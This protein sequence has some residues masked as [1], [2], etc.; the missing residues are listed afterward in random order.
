M[1]TSLGGNAPESPPQFQAGRCRLRHSLGT[2]GGPIQ[3]RAGAHLNSSPRLLVAGQ[4]ACSSRRQRGPDP[5]ARP[6]KGSVALPPAPSG[7][8]CSANTGCPEVGSRLPD[9]LQAPPEQGD[10]ACAIFGYLTTPPNNW[11]SCGCG[12]EL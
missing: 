1:L 2:P 4:A 3:P 7:T 9:K 8:S 6:E 12:G 5:H 11:E 10:Y